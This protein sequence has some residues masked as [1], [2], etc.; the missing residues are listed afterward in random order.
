MKKN[1]NS[2]YSIL[3]GVILVLFILVSCCESNDNR[4][5]GYQQTS[6][7][8]SGDEVINKI[9]SRRSAIK[10][11]LK[12][13]DGVIRSSCTVYKGEYDGHT[14]YVFYDNLASPSVVHDPNCKCLNK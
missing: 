11:Y 7:Q 9:A 4:G 8:S 5:Y 1:F 3:L 14:W 2:I 10:M 6:T 13:T 12:G